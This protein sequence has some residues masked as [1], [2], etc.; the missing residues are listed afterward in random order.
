LNVNILN[1]S[2]VGIVT[3]TDNVYYAPFYKDNNLYWTRKCVTDGSV[4]SIMTDY[5][6][7][8]PEDIMTTPEMNE[9]YINPFMCNVK[10]IYTRYGDS[11][12]WES[13]S[14]IDLILVLIRYRHNR[15]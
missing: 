14:G 1:R 6:I 9:I 12:L 11:T 7:T 4:E 8:L 5:I 13:V 10:Q 2:N 15:I 3:Q